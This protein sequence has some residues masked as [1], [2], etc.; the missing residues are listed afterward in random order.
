MGRPRVTTVCRSGKRAS[1]TVRL[2]LAAPDCPFSKFR[3]P[4][5]DPLVADASA[6]ETRPWYARRC[7][8]PSSSALASRR[9]ISERC[10]S[11]TVR[12]PR[13][14]RERIRVLIR[15]RMFVA[16]QASPLRDR[17]RVEQR[18]SVESRRAA[19]PDVPG[20][21]ESAGAI[22]H[23]RP[24]ARDRSAARDGASPRYPSARRTFSALVARTCGSSILPVWG[25]SGTPAK[26][27][28]T[29][30]CR[31]KHGLA[32]GGLVVL[33]D[34]DAVGLEGLLHR[35][36]DLLHRLP[37]ACRASP[38]RRRAGC[39]RAPWAAPAYG[40]CLAA[41][42]PSSRWCRRPRRP[43]ARGS[44]RAGS[45]RRCCPCRRPRSSASSRHSAIGNRQ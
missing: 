7:Y 31:W 39:A 22:C 35:A 8:A 4:Q 28:M 29:W 11:G 21:I 14:A 6:D 34:H 45:W 26:R 27:G 30:T 1:S 37:S 15:C 42:R 43:G 20:R 2:A 33:D 16:G 12:R 18:L 3:P 40:R 36:G 44:R 10:F 13:A 32:G 41:S 24:A 17:V 23:L 25:F 9:V 19:R 5:T 38:D